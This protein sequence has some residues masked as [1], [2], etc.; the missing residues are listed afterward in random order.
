M[1][2]FFVSANQVSATFR[3]S[4]E[5]RLFRK[6]YEEEFGKNYFFS[7][8]GCFEVYPLVSPPQRH[9]TSTFLAKQVGFNLCAQ[10]KSRCTNSVVPMDSGVHILL[11]RRS[12]SANL[13]F[14]VSRD[15]GTFIENFLEVICCICYLAFVRGLCEPQETDFRIIPESGSAGKSFDSVGSGPS[16]GC[17]QLSLGVQ[18]LE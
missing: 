9:S 6:E 5:N 4:H 15:L 8:L 16:L 13:E 17:F 18:D 1:C 2:L 14:S 3:N 11:W 7:F 10:N 12:N